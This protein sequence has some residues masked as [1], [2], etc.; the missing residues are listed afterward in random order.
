MSSLNSYDTWLGPN[1]P[2]A[3]VMRQW[4]TPVEGADAVIAPPTYAPDEKGPPRSP[5]N[6]DALKDGHNVCVLDSAP[7]QANRIEPQFG[8]VAGGKLVPRVQVAVKDGLSVDLLEIGHRVADALLKG[9][10]LRDDIEKALLEYRAGN[11]VPLARLAPTSLLFGAWDSRGTNEKIPRMISAVIRAYDVEELTRSAQYFP[12]INYEQEGVLP[13]EI[14]GK[15]SDHGLVEVPAARAPGGVM[16]RGEIRRDVM[17]NLVTLRSLSA[18]DDE[19]TRKLRR[20][21]L[22]LALVAFTAP[23]DLNLRQ[24]CLLVPDP[25]RAAE[26]A[27][28]HLDGKRRPTSLDFEGAV[29]FAKAAAADFGV[30]KSPRVATFDPKRLE[31]KLKQRKAEKAARAKVRSANSEAKVEG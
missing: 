15:P 12:P 24:G 23:P 16:V 26:C 22:G 7:S 4:L 17:L 13:S 25:E 1:G 30:E 27:L 18:A 21:I 6:I 28:V 20:Y 2:A 8:T 29:S 19:A 14:D 9:C 5:Y 31:A 3:L 10:E 11:S